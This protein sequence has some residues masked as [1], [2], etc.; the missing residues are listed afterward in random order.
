MS[1]LSAGICL[2]LHE[3]APGDIETLGSGYT[4]QLLSIKKVTP[5]ATASNPAMDRFRI[6]ISD[7]VHF[8]QA[9]LATQLNRLVYDNEIGKNTVAIIDK[10]TCNFVQDKRLIIIL[11][12]RVVSTNEDK[13]GNPISPVNLP[14]SEQVSASPVPEAS[15][16]NASIP[17]TKPQPS[18]QN[19]AAKGGRQNSIYPI[20]GLSP[21]QNNWTIKARVTQKS[22]IRTWSNQRGEGKLFNVTLMDESGEIRATGFNAVVDELYEK[23]EEGKVYLISKARVNLA[24]KKFSNV[25]NDYELSLEKHTEVEECLETSGLPMIKYN[26]ISL[27]ELEAQPKDS[28]CDVAA[29]VKEVGPLGEIVSKTNR[30]IP[31]RELTIVDKSGFSVRLTLWGKQAEQY[32]SEGHPVIAFKG[33]KVGDFG[34]RSLSMISTSMMSIDPDIDESHLL[35]G[36][37]DS[38][39]VEQAFQSHS[40]ANSSM[41]MS[42]VFN[43]SE[44]RHLSDVKE[45]QLGMSDKTDF[46]SCRSTIMH[47][48]GENISYPACPTQGCNKKVTDIGDGWRCEKCEKTFE[49]PEHRYIISLAVADWSTQAWLQGF[50]DAGVA[51]FGKSADDLMEIKER[52]EAEYNTVMAKASGATFNF[53]CRAKQDTYND[54]TRVRY[55]IV[56]LN[57][58]DYREEAKYLR[59][60]LNSPWAQ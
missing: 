35:R 36:W 47:I 41:G 10:L 21:Y 33:V 27:S 16:S 9:M 46:F 59:D 52:D 4:V 11:D 5:T 54:Q 43:R 19:Q 37:Y 45:S 55:G 22:E 26:F 2:R 23:L 12:L 44:M 39:G 58:V 31:K 29:I 7:G 28:T 1:Q 25:Q 60:L 56:K 32:N 48:K 30:T 50:N 18:R 14:A 38:I 15:T 8:V 51:V 24:K 53:T 34:G 57:P 3:A 40:N 42:T 13:I 6:I 17:Q 49:R 20:E